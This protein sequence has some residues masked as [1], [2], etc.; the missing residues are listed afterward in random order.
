[1]DP[2]GEFRVTIETAKSWLES[3]VRGWGELADE[4]KLEMVAASLLSLNRLEIA[5]DSLWASGARGQE[6][7][8]LR[9]EAGPERPSLVDLTVDERRGEA[10]ARVTLMFHDE[11][12]VGESPCRPGIGPDPTAPARATL[13]ALSVVLQDG[14]D[15][16]Q[17]RVIQILDGPF[18]L[19]TLRSQARL[20]VGSALIEGDLG[21]AMARATLDA[22]NR[23][24]RGMSHQENRSVQL[25]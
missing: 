24:I 12:L 17:A 8:D 10:T 5:L 22:A 11:S 19:V 25:T 6:E 14:L 9:V 2:G 3:V 4:R 23:F 15:F 18:A 13:E 20:L 21:I 16:E 1:M 7:T